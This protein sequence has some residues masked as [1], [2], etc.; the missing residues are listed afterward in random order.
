[1][2]VL[3]VVGPHSAQA[4][5]FNVIHTFTGGSDGYQPT[6]S[7]TLDRAGNLYGTTTDLGG[8]GTV[9]QLK[10]LSGNWV[11]NTLYTFLQSNDGFMP[12]GGVVFG[13]NGT[14]YGTT[15]MGGTGSGGGQC[16]QGCGTVF[17]LMPPAKACKTAIC[18]WTETAIYSFQGGS[19]GIDPNAALVFDRA[20]ALYGTTPRG[21]LA[22]VGVV[23]QLT[24]HNGQWTES[25]LHTF[26]GVGH[27]GAY[28]ESGMIFD[29]A[30]NLYG[31]TVAGGVSGDGTVFQLAPSGFSWTT[32]TVHDFLG[33]NGGQGPQGELTLDRSGSFYGTTTGGGLDD[34]GTVFELAYS[35]EIWA[36][37][38]LYSVPGGIDNSGPQG[39]LAMDAAGNLYGATYAGGA[40]RYGNVF[41]LTPTNS[42]W[43]YTSLHDFTDRADGANPLS[44]V[45]LD[46]NGNLYGTTSLGGMQGGNCYTLG[47]GVVW[48]ITP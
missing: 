42:G 15:Y 22:E 40:Y 16:Q 13:P 29:S 28:P 38:V 20:G 32:S 2:F 27:D 5:T 9:F 33:G 4:Q 45:T 39:Q 31:T 11:L 37:S 1:M 24:L 21:G 36:F 25:L 26:T 18:G 6:G 43:K 10:R 46:T 23:F 3:A 44:G 7:L 48:E 14:L 8:P 19:D 30:G 47:C 12:L 34:S 41:K 35:G 17:N